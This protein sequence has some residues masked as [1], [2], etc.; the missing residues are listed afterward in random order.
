MLWKP[1][2]L[3]EAIQEVVIAAGRVD[4][5]DPTEDEIEE[6]TDELLGH[7]RYVTIDEIVDDT[8]TLVSSPWPSIDDRGRRAFEPSE[9]DDEFAVDVSALDHFLTETR[10]RT[11]HGNLLPGRPPR[12]GDAFAVNEAADETLKVGSESELRPRPQHLVFDITRDARVVSAIATV[13][14]Q[15]PVAETPEDQVRP[16]ARDDLTPPSPE[17]KTADQASFK[18]WLSEEVP[19]EQLVGEV[20]EAL[21]EAAPAAQAADSLEADASVAQVLEGDELVGEEA[22]AAAAIGVGAYL[23]AGA[24]DPVDTQLHLAAGISQMSSP[25]S[26]QDVTDQLTDS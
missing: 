18:K 17:E 24:D 4:G 22:D 7:L 20:A 1:P 9:E 12:L 10:A 6:S 14:S 16:V 25:A 23:A 11:T 19:S 26:V 15:T 8:A 13:R 2:R 5:N 21:P 3:G